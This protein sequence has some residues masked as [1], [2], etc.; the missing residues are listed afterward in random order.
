LVARAKAILLQRAEEL[1]RWTRDQ[2]IVAAVV[3]QNQAPLS[4]ETI[5]DIDEAWVQGSE[6][7]GLVARLT[8][9]AC[10]KALLELVAAAPPDYYR[11][12]FV[13]DA[14]GALVCASQRTEDYWQG[15]EAKWTEAYRAGRGGIYFGPTAYDRSAER[16]LIQI[17]LPIMDGASAIGVLVVGKVV[18]SVQVGKALER[19]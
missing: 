15:D 9:N 6:V 11:E 16:A 10:A 2:R 8:S 5:H 14:R 1:R 17:S 19:D 13:A 3:A 7:D 12:A 4:A 18:Q